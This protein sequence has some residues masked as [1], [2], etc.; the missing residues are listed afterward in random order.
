MAGIYDDCRL[1][2]RKIGGKINLFAGC[3]EVGA[4][5]FRT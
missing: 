1:E 2:G 5:G 3:V 4:E